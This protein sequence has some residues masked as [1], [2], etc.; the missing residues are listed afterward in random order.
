[1]D[2][3]RSCTSGLDSFAWMLERYLESRLDGGRAGGEHEDSVREV[4]RFFHI[5]G[6]Q[7]DGMAF[8]RQNPQQLLAHSQAH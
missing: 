1:M 2:S 7:H 5:M 4:N 8:Y 6:N 3:L